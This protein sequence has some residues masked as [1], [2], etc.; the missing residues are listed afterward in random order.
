MK[1]EVGA[2]TRKPYGT[3]QEFMKAA[4]PWVVPL[5][6]CWSKRTLTTGG[7]CAHSRAG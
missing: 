3:K 2:G 1:A 6:F 4:A 5:N 7:K